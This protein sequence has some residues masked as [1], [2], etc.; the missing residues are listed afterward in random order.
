MSD[1]TNQPG[2][3]TPEAGTTVQEIRQNDIPFPIESIMHNAYLQYSLSVNIGRAI[4]DVRDGCKVGNRRILFAMRQLGFFKS[5]SYEKCAKVVGEVIGNYHPHGDMAVYDTLV[6]MAQDFSM[7]APLIDG[8]GNF[9]T[10]D[11]DQAAAYRYTECRMERL[12]EEL[13]ADLD[14][15]TVDMRPTFDEKAMEPTV[16][17]AKFP[18][19]LVNGTSGIGVG[20]ATSIPPHNLGEA[21]DAVIAVIDN[22]MITVRE[23]M[24]RIP[25]PDFPTGGIIVGMRSIVSLYETGRGTIKLRG[26]ANIE[27]KNG[28]ERIIITEIPYGI[29]KEVM[30]AKI[31][32][33]V[34]DKRITGISDIKDVTSDRVGIRIEIDIKRGAIAS[35]VLNQLYALTPLMST[36]GCQFLVVDRNRPRTMNLKQVLEAYIDHRE[37]VITRRLNYELAEAQKRQHI[38]EGL[39]I[40]QANIDEV[41]HIIR[42]SPNREEAGK[43]LIARFNLSDIQAKAIL[44]M[45]LYQLTNLAVDELT[46][47]HDALAKRISEIQDILASREKIMNVVKTELI[48][49]KMKYANA[50]RTLIMAAEH[51]ANLEDMFAREICVIPVSASGYIKRVAASNYEAQSRGGKGVKGMRTKDEDFVE[52]LLTCCTHDSILFFTNKGL[53]HQ[54]KAYEIPE[55]SRDGQGKAVVNLLQLENDERIR[56]MIP[57][58]SLTIPGLYVVMVTRKGIIKKTALAAFKNL[59]KRGLI[60]ILLEEGDDLIEAKLTNGKQEIMLSSAHGMACR[61][62]ET[63]IRPSGRSSRGV[64][65]MKLD[66]RNGEEPSEI[67]AMSI[68]EADDELLV[69]TARGMGKRSAI[70]AS[71]VAPEDISLE[72]APPPAEGDE[73]TEE[74]AIDVD[75]VDVDAVETLEA[76]D[77]TE[78]QDGDEAA[79]ENADGAEA[80][81]AVHGG[82]RLTRRGTK[83]VTSI[84]LRGGDRVVAALQIPRGADPEILITTVQGLMV[85]VH[86]KDVRQTGRATSGVIVMRLNEGDSVASA[87]VIDEL[88]PE[89]IAANQAKRDELE[90]IAKQEAAFKEKYGKGDAQSQADAEEGE[91]EELEEGNEGA[92]GAEGNEAAEG[93]EPESEPPAGN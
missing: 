67:V 23:L 3:G 70:G 77:E 62:L 66:G 56:A 32:E 21:I 24:T 36:V 90:S 18:N 93:G 88:S 11:G 54:L 74:E 47:E 80:G 85:R 33:L 84:K 46:A 71:G 58:A 76:E 65:G 20:M 72:D 78:E 2:N 1:D 16:L 82:Y 61:F 45:R 6:R 17:P 79:A 91:D 29:Y 51:E 55:S 52:M 75:A 30:V 8:H 25:G 10:I 27:E 81:A 31:A 60:A 35:V 28:K 42:K 12:A 53:V 68:V 5:H 13:L 7:R 69:I 57:I 87:A 64:R 26:K 43:Q 89:E 86:V 49:V 9:G 41:V 14:K 4:P 39:M 92:E 34:N 63:Q 83:G 59:R 50:R 37:E 22:P 38:V 48:E 44:E 73:A 40:A 19:L 15:D